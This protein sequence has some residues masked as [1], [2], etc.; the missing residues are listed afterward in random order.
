M[1]NIVSK[2]LSPHG[3]MATVQ[4]EV[5]T[6]GKYGTGPTILISI[7]KRQALG[8]EVKRVQGYLFNSSEG[9]QRSFK[10]KKVKLKHIGQLFFT[11]MCTDRYLGLSGLVLGLGGVGS[12]SLM[13]HGPV[14]TCEYVNSCRPFFPNNWPKVNIIGDVPINSEPLI[15]HSDDFVEIIVVTIGSIINDRNRKEKNEGEPLRKKYKKDTADATSI[16]N[17][18]LPFTTPFLPP[19]NIYICELKKQ[20]KIKNLHDCE[21]PGCEDSKTAIVECCISIDCIKATIEYFNV[22]HKDVSKIYHLFPPSLSFKNINTNEMKVDSIFAYYKSQWEAL[23]NNT[24]VIHIYLN[25][26][27]H[28]NNRLD[29]SNSI[30]STINDSFVSF[31]A[32]L[33]CIAPQNFQLPDFINDDISLKGLFD[34]EVSNVKRYLNRKK[35]KNVGDDDDQEYNNN[36]NKNNNNNNDNSG[37]IKKNNG[38]TIAIKKTERNVLDLNQKAANEL[39]NKMTLKTHQITHMT[40]PELIF[41]G[42]GSAAPSTLRNSSSIYLNL[43]K[44]FLGN[45]LIDVGE[46]TY[47]QLVRLYG[48]KKSSVLIKSLRVIWISHH[49]IDHHLGLLRIIEE[50]MTQIPRSNSDNTNNRPN[51]AMAVTKPL[52]IIGPPIVKHFLIKAAPRLFQYYQYYNFFEFTSAYHVHNILNQELGVTALINV[53]VN[54]CRDSHGL[55]LQLKSGE[56]IVYSGDTRPCTNLINAG[57]NATVLIHEATFDDTMMDDAIKKRHSTVS[58]ALN[59]GKSMQAYSVILT[60]F[61]QRYPQIV[62]KKSNKVKESHENADNGSHGIEKA[63]VATKTKENLNTYIDP[64][65]AFD[66]MHI[67]IND[68]DLQLARKSTKNISYYLLTQHKQNVSHKR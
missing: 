7:Y 61:S 21:D 54:H 40:A 19:V 44:P 68:D 14:G 23:L 24:N 52:I 36:D 5:I 13:V 48:A 58:E 65:L 50:R 39:R 43:N 12:E 26:T 20:E 31:Q 45:I 67:H 28:D 16:K 34:Q 55:V 38:G 10:E 37:L 62:Q 18:N 64:I 11:S 66:M 35:I 60:H 27:E 4:S 3:A 46:G 63:V 51:M 42:T 17:L 30:V 53:P 6:S 47:G 59:V 49:H 33:H 32:Q 9:L 22:N 1:K 41:L 25:K 56:K 15:V 29:H 8:G 57:L 2:Y